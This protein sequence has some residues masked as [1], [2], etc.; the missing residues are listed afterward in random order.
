MH[1]RCLIVFNCCASEKR[2]FCVRC[3]GAVYRVELIYA[4][5]V[6]IVY[7]LW[8]NATIQNDAGPHEGAA[9]VLRTFMFWQFVQFMFMR[10]DLISV[11]L[12]ANVSVYFRNTGT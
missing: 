12:T 4:T 3:A 5:P 8:L 9:H 6:F 11:Y 1:V 2:V 10:F 7:R